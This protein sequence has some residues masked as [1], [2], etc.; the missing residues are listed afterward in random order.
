[1]KIKPQEL[2]KKTSKE[3]EDMKKQLK[4]SLSESYGM[5]KKEDVKLEMGNIKKNIARINTIQTERRE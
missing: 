2:R 4:V 3:L 5:M 1:M